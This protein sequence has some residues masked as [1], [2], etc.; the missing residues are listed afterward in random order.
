MYMYVCTVLCMSSIRIHTE[1]IHTY[2]RHMTYDIYKRRRKLNLSE[3]YPL[4]PLLVPSSYFL[5]FSPYPPCFLL[6][7]T[8]I[9]TI[10]TVY[11]I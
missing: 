6:H 10:I 9:G 3:L 4:P 8:K 7:V 5:P 2:I 11:T 1:Y